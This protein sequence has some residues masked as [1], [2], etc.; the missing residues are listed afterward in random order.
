MSLNNII[1][2][3]SQRFLNQK[4]SF[5]TRLTKIRSP[6][7]EGHFKEILDSCRVT[8]H[9]FSP[10]SG[11][12]PWLLKTIPL[13]WLHWQTVQMEKSG[14]LWP[15]RSQH[16]RFPCL[17][18]SPGVCSN[19]CASNH[20]ILYHPFF[21]LPSIFPSIGVFSNELAL[22]IR[23]PKCWCFSFSI[24][25]SDEYSGFISFRTNWFDLLAG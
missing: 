15:N 17:S 6:L 2:S 24:S 7:P 22:H 4:L 12:L 8:I 10:L 1:S 19:S 18:P 20:L 11:S 25:P 21:L 14:S 5:V 16:A 23:W 9:S 13:S 3:S